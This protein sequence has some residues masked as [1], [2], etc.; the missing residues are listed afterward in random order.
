MAPSSSDSARR[1]ESTTA[2]AVGQP[3]DKGKNTR[4][5]RMTASVLKLSAREI[6]KGNRRNRVVLW[7][8]LNGRQFGSPS[9][10]LVA[11]LEAANWERI[12]A[13]VKA[14]AKAWRRFGVSMEQAA[15]ALKVLAAA[16]ARANS[17]RS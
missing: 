6:R 9:D 10:L 7:G 5:A 13:S 2:P 11:Q 17:S 3:P 1:S 15:C 4:A 16:N 12:L 14:F 8:K